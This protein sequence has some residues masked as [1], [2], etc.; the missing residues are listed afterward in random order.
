MDDR[1]VYLFAKKLKL[2]E[3]EIKTSYKEALTEY[4]IDKDEQVRKPCSYKFLSGENS[5]K[6]CGLLPKN[7]LVDASCE[8]DGKYYC[9]SHYKT[10]SERQR[11]SQGLR[12]TGVQKP[13]QLNEKLETERMGDFEVLKGTMLIIDRTKNCCSGKYVQEQP[14]TTINKKDEVVLSEKNIPYYK[15]VVKDEEEIDINSTEI[16]FDDLIT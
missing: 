1:L 16:D 10:I 13:V 11:K 5:G 8:I 3:Q 12:L 9:K 7:I 6:L 14:T 4:I 15:C 2:T